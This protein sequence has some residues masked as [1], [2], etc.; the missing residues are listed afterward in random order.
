MIRVKGEAYYSILSQ[1]ARFNQ[2]KRCNNLAI[3]INLTFPIKQDSSQTATYIYRVFKIPDLFKCLWSELDQNECPFLL[4]SKPD[5]NNNPNP[6]RIRIRKT[7]FLGGEEG[8]HLF[9]GLLQTCTQEQF[10][11][12]FRN[13]MV[14]KRSSYKNVYGRK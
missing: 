8:S 14:Q 7:E 10:S 4:N 1:Q 6:I 9:R 12:S 2:T 13:N 11:K 3:R 5:P